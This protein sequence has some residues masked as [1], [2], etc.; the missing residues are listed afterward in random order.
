MCGG[1]TAIDRRDLLD[2][3]QL[4]PGDAVDS[5]HHRPRQACHRVRAYEEAG[6]FVTDLSVDE[7][8]LR[9]DRRL[10]LIVREGPRIRIRSVAFEGNTVFSDGELKK[11]VEADE[12][13]P[14]IGTKHVVNREQLEL[15]AA[16]LRGLLP[17]PRLPRGAGRPTHHRL[18]QPARQRT[19]SS[20]SPRGR[21]GTIGDVRIEGLDK[22]ELIFTPEQLRLVMELH[23][24][25]IYSARDLKS[26][27]GN[28]LNLYGRLGYLDTRL[29]RRVRSD[30]TPGIDRVF[31]SETN[32]VDL[33]VTIDQGRPT[34]VGK[35]T[36]RG[37]GVTRSKGRPARA[38]RHHPRSAIRPRKDSTNHVV[39]STR[40]RCFRTPPSPS[41]ATLKTSS[42]MC[43]SRSTSATL[44]RSL[45]ARPSAPTTALLGTIGR[46]PAQLRR[47]RHP[48]VLGRPA[49]QPRVPRR[50]PDVQPLAL[51]RQ[52]EQPLRQSV[53]RT[54]T[55]STATTTPTSSSPTTPA[56]ASIT[57]KPAARSA[58]AWG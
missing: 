49:V 11:Q 39:V 57:T 43:W 10:V 58:S 56:T 7:R 34:T 27:T 28:L 2:I 30:P 40:A 12:Y 36:V 9:E 14:I 41:S 8:A 45:L 52:P 38:A 29:I 22:Q 23:P 13:V 5:L 33:L 31:R 18:R 44:A 37:N 50:R 26:S 1:N 3:I 48:R 6:Y 42:A 35:V 19:S 47:H 17:G 55:S 32:T 46:H 20:R 24:G 16:R 15:D 21:C 4:R 54:R 53:C 25:D 51:A